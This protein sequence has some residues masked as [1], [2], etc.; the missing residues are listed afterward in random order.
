MKIFCAKHEIHFSEDFPKAKNC[1]LWEGYGMT[2]LS[3]DL[4]K[5]VWD[6]MFT[7]PQDEIFLKTGYGIQFQMSL[8]YVG[9]SENVFAKHIKGYKDWPDKKRKRFQKAY[10]KW[11]KKYQEKALLYLFIETDGRK[12][13]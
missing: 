11:Q 12:F 9:K 8:V 6:W 1:P 7:M 3:E 5:K 2:E 4:K 10:F 13:K